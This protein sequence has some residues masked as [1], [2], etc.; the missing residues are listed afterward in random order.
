M[1]DTQLH[2]LTHNHL[3][4]LWICKNEYGIRFLRNGFQIRITWHAI[5]RGYMR[6]DRVDLIPGIL[7][8]KIV[9]IATCFSLLR[10]ADNSDFLLS[11]KIFYKEINF[12][13]LASFCIYLFTN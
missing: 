7:E 3:S 4:H 8:F 13:H 10:N 11:K 2:T 9:R 12:G 6:I 5:I 1:L